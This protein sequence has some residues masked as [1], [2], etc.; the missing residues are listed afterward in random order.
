MHICKYKHTLLFWLG[1][2]AINRF[3]AL[4][5]SIEMSVMYI[6]VFHKCLSVHSAA[7]L[8]LFQKQ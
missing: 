2:I 7:T 8:T 6:L 1:L 3:T 4:K 5:V